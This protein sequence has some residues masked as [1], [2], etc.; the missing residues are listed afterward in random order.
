MAKD[1]KFSEEGFSCSPCGPPDAPGVYAICVM[2]NFYGE[3]ST[4]IDRVVYIGSSSNINKR[5][6]KPTHIYRRLFNLLKNYWVYTLFF[7]CDEYVEL[8]KQLIRK[9]K[10]RFNRHLYGS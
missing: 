6:L 10:P 4:F 8:E 5:I 9:Y 1:Q 2:Q 7:T 3:K